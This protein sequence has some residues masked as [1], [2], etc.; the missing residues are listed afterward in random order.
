MVL[1]WFDVLV[2]EDSSAML[3]F[4]E[5]VQLLDSEAEVRVNITAMLDMLREHNLLKPLLIGD[6]HFKSAASLL[7]FDVE[8]TVV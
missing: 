8:A 7:A 1:T 3:I 6:S 4:Q 2:R 5:L